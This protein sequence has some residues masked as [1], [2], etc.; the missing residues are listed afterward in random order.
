[1]G[2]RLKMRRVDAVP[3]AAKMVKLKALGDWPDAQLVGEPMCQVN[4]S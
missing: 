4:T 1:M 2:D 3:H